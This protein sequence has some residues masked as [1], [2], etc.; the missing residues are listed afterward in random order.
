M[1]IYTNMFEAVKETERELIEM[2]TIVHPET[3]QDLKVKGNEEFETKELQG[4]AYAITSNSKINEDF[5]KLGGSL[6]YANAEYIERISPQWINPGVAYQFR[7][8][9]WKPFIH[10]GRFSYTYNERIREQLDF[11]IEELKKN[12]NT[13][14]AIIS[15]YDRHQDM[16]NIG[17][18][19]RIPCSMYYQLLR[20][21]KNGKEVL[22]II[23]TMRSCDIYAH[24][25]YDIFV[26]MK[27]QE[28]ISGSLG[29]I[30]GTFT[31]FI[32]SLH[33]Y[34]RD[35]GKKGVF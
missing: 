20:R 33:A 10:E 23:Y 34:K 2:G 29:I 11:I 21:V 19:S 25:I 1:R 31:H 24:F 15:I 27:L 3:M 9:V 26:T 8:K 13:R 22:D 12:P 18:K 35:Y 7:E 17:G 32:G 30:P 14:Q 5:E 28:F 4:Y 16:S 6:E